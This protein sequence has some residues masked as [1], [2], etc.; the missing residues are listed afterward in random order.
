MERLRGESPPPGAVIVRTRAGGLGRAVG[1]LAPDRAEGGLH[2][3]GRGESAEAGGN[4]RVE[5]AYRAG[6]A[7]ESARGIEKNDWPLTLDLM[8]TATHI[9]QFPTMRQAGRPPAFFI[10][11]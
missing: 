1:Q 10:S 2:A 11:G 6:E 8:H 4:F 3:G 9:K 5:M 7:D